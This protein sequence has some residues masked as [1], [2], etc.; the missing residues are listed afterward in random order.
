MLIVLIPVLVAV[1]V[2]AAILTITVVGRRRGYSGLGGDTVV[3]CSAGHQFTTIWVPGASL[4]AIRFG[5]RRYQR[6]PIGH[7]W[8]MVVPLRDDQLTEEMRREAAL[9]HDVHLP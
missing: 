4:K 2:V 1:V 8:A 9:H 7:H 3:R 6:C 5:T